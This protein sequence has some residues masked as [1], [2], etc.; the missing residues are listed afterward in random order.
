MKSLFVEFDILTNVARH[1]KLE[2]IS[3]DALDSLSRVA[4]LPSTP[5]LT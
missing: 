4:Y 1:A 2:D 5:A 3:R